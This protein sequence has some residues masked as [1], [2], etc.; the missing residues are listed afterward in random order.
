MARANGIELEY[1]LER[2]REDLGL[3][4]E[5]NGKA[6]LVAC[7]GGSQIRASEPYM[8]DAKMLAQQLA[9]AGISIITGG[10]SGVMDAANTGAYTV[11]SKRSYGLRVK[12]IRDEIDAVSESIDA[13]QIQ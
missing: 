12:T 8:N 7:F 6:P 4:S 10:G 3:C 1:S 5:L 13:E 2:Y 11:S 9:G